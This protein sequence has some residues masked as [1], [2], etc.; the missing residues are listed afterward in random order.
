VSGE[1]KKRI[2][3]AIKIDVDKCT[4]CQACEVACATFHSTPKYSSV[5]PA[6]S[7]VRVI[8]DELANVFLPVLAGAYVEAE[9]DGRHNY[10]IN[11]RDYGECNFCNASCPSR[12][13]FK[14]PD[15]GLPLKCDMC[16]EEPP[17]EEPMCVQWCLVDALT[18]EQREE[19]V[20]EEEKPWELEIGLESLVNKYG[21]Q[22]VRDTLARMSMSKKG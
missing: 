12:D 9:C 13:L 21:L 19:E 16:E 14:E 10:I 4:G 6:R 3:K 15:S 7:R 17:L 18:Y 22:K 5:N 20:E 1:K 11:G 2:I 8:R